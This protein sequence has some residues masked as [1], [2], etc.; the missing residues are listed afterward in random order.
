MK[1]ALTLIA[2]ALSI[3]LLSPIAS[4]DIFEDIWN[5]PESHVGVSRRG[6]SGQPI[7]PD[8]KVTV[9]EQG[10]GGN[11][12]GDDHA[13]RPLLSHVDESLL[14]EPTFRTFIAL[15]DNYTAAQR[16]TETDSTK[17][18]D[19]HWKEVDAFVDAVFATKPMQLA[20]ARNE[21]GAGASVSDSAGG[22]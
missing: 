1:T 8:A 15:L 12:I 3:L 6:P 21:N 19:P 7:D 5:L 2:A 18:N 20:S 17:R 13:P 11:C 16:K 14:S 10:Q 22:F 9:D 4:A